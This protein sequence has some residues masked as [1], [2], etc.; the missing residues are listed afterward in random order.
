MVLDPPTITLHNFRAAMTVEVKEKDDR[1]T[2]L[3]N[4]VSSLKVS[5]LLFLITSHYLFLGSRRQPNRSTIAI[6][7]DSD[8][9]ADSQTATRPSVENL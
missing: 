8:H 5:T 7:L 4:E 2:Q 6:L 3:E 1:I 9:S